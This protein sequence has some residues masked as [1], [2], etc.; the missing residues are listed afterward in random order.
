MAGGNHNPLREI[1]CMNQRGYGGESSIA[2]PASRRS[3]RGFSN[4]VGLRSMCSECKTY[5][6]IDLRLSPDETPYFL[7][8]V[9]TPTCPEFA[10]IFNA[11][12][13]MLWR[14]QHLLIGGRPSA[15]SNNVFRHS[16]ARCHAR[17]SAARAVDLLVRLSSQVTCFLA[18]VT[19][20][21]SR[22]REM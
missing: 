6:R 19:R 1:D 18:V 3:T 14:A 11:Q 10:R 17:S 20:L 12:I 13:F 16:Q 2:G 15:V 9:P 7:K 4:S 8:R 22:P 5:V 21:L